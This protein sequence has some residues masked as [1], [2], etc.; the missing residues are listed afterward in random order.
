MQKGDYLLSRDCK[1]V[2]QVVGRYGRDVVLAIISE[3]SDEVLIYDA[4]ELERLI[5]TGYFRKLHK[6]GIKVN[7]EGGMKNG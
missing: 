5:T 7:E 6:T 3:E 2:Y 4:A 1:N